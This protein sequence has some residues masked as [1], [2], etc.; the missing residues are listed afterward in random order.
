[1][2]VEPTQM[3]SGIERLTDALRRYRRLLVLC[4][5][6]GVAVALVISA[7][8]EPEYRAT[9]QVL[10]DEEGTG[11]ILPGADANATDAQR[12]A[13]TAVTLAGSGAFYDRVSLR[14]HG[15]ASR[16]D[17]P[18][19]PGDFSVDEQ[20]G[21]S[22]LSITATASGA[23]TAQK[24]ANAVAAEFPRFR[25]DTLQRPLRQTERSL[26]SQLDDNPD[27]QQIQDS[28]S[29]VRVLERL[30]QRSAAVVDSA[31]SADKI[32][33]IPAR[34]AV[35]GLVSGLV[36]GLLLMALREGL[37]SRVREDEVV[38]RALGARVV[39]SL[40]RR[41]RG[42]ERT[43]AAIE[44]LVVLLGG[45]RNPARD[46][47]VCVLGGAG[48]KRTG[49]IAEA[50]RAELSRRGEAVTQI[51]AD[52][53]L[54]NGMAGVLALPEGTGA[55]AEPV[56]GAVAVTTGAVG[57]GWV[58]VDGPQDVASALVLEL[59]RVADVVVLAVADDIARRELVA[60]SRELDMWPRRPYVAVLTLG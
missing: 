49:E 59:V 15:L 23:A 48:V 16:V 2:N 7:V 45:H 39:A 60:L 31:Q 44:R 3:T 22:L 29:R 30:A 1:V 24:L 12:S 8:S 32:R 38:E 53:A 9:A 47:V 6:A 28:L 42:G 11:A 50:V 33:P 10:L 54:D 18:A 55:G 41:D 43:A 21:T 34:D 4:V 20:P 52:T 14:F 25:A 46:T 40:P 19:L 58:V 26:Q 17:P 57:G 56:A 13:S 27:D 37:S 36:I 5:L 35:I 51:V